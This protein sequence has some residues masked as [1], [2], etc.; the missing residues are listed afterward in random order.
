MTLWA[1]VNPDAEQEERTFV[2]IAT[3]EVVADSPGPFVG[4]VILQWGQLV[5]H[6]FEEV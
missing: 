1:A 3:G 2:A 6:I 4:T 5:F